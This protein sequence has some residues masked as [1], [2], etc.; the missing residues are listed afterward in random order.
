MSVTIKFL[1]LAG[2]GMIVTLS[3]LTAEDRRQREVREMREQIRAELKEELA[4]EFESQL[5]DRAK[6]QSTAS[7]PVR[8][9]EPESTVT[10]VESAVDSALLEAQEARRQ[11][12]ERLRAR[13]AQLAADTRGQG[14]IA[15]AQEMQA[16]SDQ[17]VALEISEAGGS[18][19]TY[20]AQRRQSQIQAQA[21]EQAYDLRRVEREIR[22]Q[23]QEIERQRRELEA[24][25]LQIQDQERNLRRQSGGS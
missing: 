9:L 22:A 11:L 13:Y 20:V 25:Q 17:L 16:I 8:T 14:S 3:W 1:L 10:V 23:Q 15:R 6:I 18:G 5:S 19:S 4:R 21:Q 2:V 12:K 24:Q 7:R